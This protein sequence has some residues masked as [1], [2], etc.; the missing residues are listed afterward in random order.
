MMDEKSKAELDLTEIGSILK[1]YSNST[2]N[3]PDF[4]KS[5]DNINGW[6][7]E[8]RKKGNEENIAKV[9]V[10]L[11]TAVNAL[12][13]FKTGDPYDAT[14]GTLEIILSVAAVAGGLLAWQFQHCVALLELSFWRT[15]QPNQ[16]W[17]NS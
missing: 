1:V 14:C 5:I 13:K 4:Q 3:K 7:N 16:A 17:W 6:V 12:E 11:K 10:A 2:Q 8:Q 15:S 9:G